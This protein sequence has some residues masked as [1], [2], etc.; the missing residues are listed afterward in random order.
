MLIVLLLTLSADPSPIVP[1]KLERKEPVDFDKEIKP[2]FAAKCTVCHAG[3]VTEN[4]YDMSTLAGVIKGGKKRGGGRA[5]ETG[6][7]HPLP[8]FDEPEKADHA[9][10]DGG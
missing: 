9:A 4:G 6:R 3:K 2:I 5:G 8:G 10:E 7:E 1:A